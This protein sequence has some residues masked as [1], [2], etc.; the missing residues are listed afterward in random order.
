MANESRSLSL[1]A[2]TVNVL[3]EINK[4]GI[5]FITRKKLGREQQEIKGWELEKFLSIDFLDE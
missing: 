2:Q 4:R 3:V 1:V 5:V